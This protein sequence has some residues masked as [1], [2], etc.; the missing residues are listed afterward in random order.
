MQ[1]QKEEVSWKERVLYTLGGLTLL[2]AGIFFGRKLILHRV[3]D[4]EE[5]RTAEEGSSAAIAKEIKMAFENDG[6]WGTDTERLRNSI[7]QISSKE[8]FNEVIKSYTKLYQSNLMKDMSDELQ[9]SEF[10][11]MMN[12]IN[13][14]PDRITNGTS[15]IV[16][17]SAWA[18]RLKAAFDKKYGFIP[19]TDENAIKAVFMEIP[20]Q[21][22]FVAVG[23]AYQQEFGNDLI[24][25]LKSELEIWEYPTYMAIITSKPT[26]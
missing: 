17:Y 1:N 12:I 9:S 20:T 18:K 6:W 7:R 26:N 21:Q 14:K 5:T 4:K 24:T 3:A 16:N 25:D 22:A 23:K 2:G 10:N 13:A 15:S 11:E 8:M 19:G